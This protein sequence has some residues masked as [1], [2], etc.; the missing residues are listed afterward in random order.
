MRISI[1]RVKTTTWDLDISDDDLRSAAE[2]SKYYGPV[3]QRDNE[4][5]EAWIDRLLASDAVLEAL[6]CEDDATEVYEEYAT[7]DVE[8]VDSSES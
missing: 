1:E 5:R 7:T 4:S 3:G 6:T 8:D 2:R